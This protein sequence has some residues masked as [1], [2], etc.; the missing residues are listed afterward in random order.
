MAPVP[1]DQRSGLQQLKGKRKEPES[2]GSPRAPDATRT[3]SSSAGSDENVLKTQRTSPPP[4]PLDFTPL[5]FNNDEYY[6][7]VRE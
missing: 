2:G 1:S 7:F 4:S 5:E 6:A 3:R